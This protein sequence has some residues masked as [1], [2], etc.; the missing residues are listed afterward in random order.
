MAALSRQIR[1]EVTWK[2]I[3]SYGGSHYNSLPAGDLRTGKRLDFC[4]QPAL[5]GWNPSAGSENNTPSF[6]ELH[7]SQ[8]VSPMSLVY[9]Q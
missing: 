7:L 4:E 5:C 6:A 2:W 9:M 8:V 1:F 3:C